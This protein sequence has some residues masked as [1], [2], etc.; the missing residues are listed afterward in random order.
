MTRDHGMM[1]ISEY[2][3]AYVDA[4]L[5]VNMQAN[6]RSVTSCMS[7][8]CTSS[9]EDEDSLVSWLLES[10]C[11]KLSQNTKTHGTVLG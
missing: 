4:M 1:L 8:R 7:E 2:D 10:S 9:D 11:R 6:T 5:M 3:D